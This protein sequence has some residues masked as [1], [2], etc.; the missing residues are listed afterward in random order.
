MPADVTFPVAVKA[1]E[2]FGSRHIYGADDRAQ[3]EYHLAYT[4]VLVRPVVVQGE[5]FSIDVLC[6][7]SAPA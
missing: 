5:E 7:L 1:R 4:P 3:L 6:D 2:G